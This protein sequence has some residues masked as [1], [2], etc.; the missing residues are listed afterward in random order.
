MGN[1]YSTA[2]GCRGPDV[3]KELLKHAAAGDV[4]ALNSVL[5]DN[6]RLV[7][8]YSVFGGNSAWHKAAKSGNVPVLEALE[9]AV[10]RQYELG[11]K[12]LS[13][14]LSKPG[15]LRLGS[16]GPDAVTRLINKSNIK[17]FT[18][19]MLACS[20]SH[21]AAVSWLIKHGTCV[22]WRCQQLTSTGKDWRACLR[23][24]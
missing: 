12:D 19:L 16:S 23:W 2:A 24:L 11:S 6:S 22:C 21:T 14:T 15:V 18:P 13:E 9:A 7:S 10:L 20:G 4:D 5:D 8:H 3:A 17:G 1:I